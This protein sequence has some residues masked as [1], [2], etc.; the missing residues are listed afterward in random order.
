M[1]QE[2]LNYTTGFIITQDYN[3]LVQ[4]M[5]YDNV[6]EVIMLIAANFDELVRTENIRNLTKLACIFAG[7]QYN[8]EYK[9]VC[10]R[11]RRITTTFNRD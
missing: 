1:E 9:E 5:C 11:I 3:A 4:L 6:E 2:I 8:R 10:A 7:T